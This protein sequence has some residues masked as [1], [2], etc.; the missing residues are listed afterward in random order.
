MG[1]EHTSIDADLAA[2]I[3]A[4][5]LFFVATAPLAGEGRINCSPKGGQLA[6]ID[7]QRVAYQDLTGSGCETIAHL[8]ENGRIVVMLCAFAGPPR[9]VRL[10]G[11]GTVHLQGDAAFAALAAAFP[12]HAGTRAIIHV[13]VE[14]VSTSCG[15]G[16]PLYQFE[17]PRTDLD[18]WSERKGE[19]GMAEY[20]QRKNQR[21]ID[22]LPA[23]VPPGTADGPRAS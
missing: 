5:H 10:H 23:L 1:Q 8:R 2:W 20:R 4:Q 22:G 17:R 19:A 12:A 14:R 3:A 15:F 18:T 6:V 7:P 16:V 9:I 13:D 21:S 11:R